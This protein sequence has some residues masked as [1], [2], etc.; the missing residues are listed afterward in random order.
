MTAHT[1]QRDGQD[2]YYEIH[3]SGPVLLLI[4]SYLCSSQMWAH[5]IETLST[6]H[7]VIAVDLRGHGHSSPSKP[8][9]LYDLVDDVI[10]VLDH[11]GIGCAVWCGLSIGGM[12]TMRAALRYPERV[13]AIILV[14]TDG[15]SEAP[16]IIFKHKALAVF[17]RLFGVKPVLSSIMKLMFGKHARR[18]QPALMNTWR[19]ALSQVHVP[20]MMRTLKALDTRDD[21]MKTLATIACPICIIHG[22]EDTA[23]PLHRGRALALALPHSTFVELEQCGHLS[24]LEHPDA[25]NTHVVRFLRQSTRT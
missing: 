25:F 4:H 18:N 5:E 7:R 2:L 6:D 13:S 17:T 16:K 10:A 9:D 19:Q 21:V 14:D 12:I 8:H 22:D 15:M 24:N 23:I 1:L 20:S 3:G 11:A